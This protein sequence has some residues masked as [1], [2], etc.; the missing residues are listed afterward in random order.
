MYTH[1]A[2]LGACSSAQTQPSEGL[3]YT[4]QAILG[5]CSSDFW[6]TRF[7]A[8]DFISTQVAQVWLDL[9]SPH[10]TAHLS[11][12][13]IRRHTNNYCYMTCC[14]QHKV[15]KRQKITRF[16]F[17]TRGWGLDTRLSRRV[18]IWVEGSTVSNIV[19]M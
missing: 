10:N 1:Q 2:I 18:D 4:H 12:A 8:Y 7:T 16:L 5:A 15:D 6:H 17:L 14:I 3:V 13:T 19:F 11:T 9:H